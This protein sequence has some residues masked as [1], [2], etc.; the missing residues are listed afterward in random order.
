M[1]Y[2]VCLA[3]IE[4]CVNQDGPNCLQCE[5]GY[6]THG[7][8]K[9]CY[10]DIEHCKN[11]YMD[12]CQECE[13]GYG[14]YSDDSRCYKTVENCLNQVQDVCKQCM[15]GY[16]TFGDPYRC[17][18]K[19]P[20]AAYP[21]SVPAEGGTTCVCNA[22]KGYT[23]D[24]YG[25]KYPRRPKAII[26]KVMKITKNGIITTSCIAI[27][28]ENMTRIQKGVSAIRDTPETAAPNAVRII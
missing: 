15:P 11:Q 24:P 25:N 5:T 4:H 9:K 27:P 14:T 26:T 6:G 12:I 10:P 13:A 16:D 19:N 8:S 3:K 1:T 2:N 28:T 23:G 20:C 7:D 21:N 17:Y 22:D 18:D